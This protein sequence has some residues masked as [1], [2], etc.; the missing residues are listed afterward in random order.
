MTSRWTKNT[1]VKV[2]KNDSF[3]LFTEVKVET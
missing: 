2:K 3:E 1:L